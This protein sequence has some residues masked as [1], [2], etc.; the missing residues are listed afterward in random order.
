MC[1]LGVLGTFYRKE[2]SNFLNP[3]MV[4]FLP[5]IKKPCLTALL[6]GLKVKVFVPR[7]FYFVGC[8]RLLTRQVLPHKAESVNIC[9][10][11]GR[12]HTYALLYAMR[13]RYVAPG[14]ASGGGGMSTSLLR[15]ASALAP[16]AWG[17]PLI[18][19]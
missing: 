8:C 16:A 15:P 11:L 12:S 18:A 7:G 10:W 4:I 3:E 14:E 9:Y 5:L 17:G 13:V 2:S 1:L 19:S 6:L